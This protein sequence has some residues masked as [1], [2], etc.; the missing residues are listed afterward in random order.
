METHQG[1]FAVMGNHL[2]ND[3][4]EFVEP[5]RFMRVSPA[6]RGIVLRGAAAPT[7]KLLGDLGYIEPFQIRT[8][9]AL[10]D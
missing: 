1:Y 4:V 10:Q 2:V 3:L 8:A 7:S 5:R 9:V 6:L